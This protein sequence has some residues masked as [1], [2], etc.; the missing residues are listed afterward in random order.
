MKTPIDK[1][2]HELA[3][4]PSVGERTALRMAL[5][6]LRQPVGFGQ[7]LA[8]AL[9]EAVER[10]RFCENCAHITADTYCEYCQDVR[11]DA[12][13]VC[14]VEEVADLLAIER[15]HRYRGVYHVLHGVISPIDG[16]G[17]DDLRIEL[18]LK[19][20]ATGQVREIIL[21]LSPSV[22]GEATS[23]YMTR[24]MRG[25]PVKITK[26]ASGIPV[27]ATIEFIDQNTLSRA[28]EARVEV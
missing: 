24:L 11:R 10:A 3:K 12:S 6:I 26:L 16:V 21:A 7:G 27:G 1:L 25:S 4:L 23:L 17:P 2:V 28:M 22:N 9:R 20:M 19:R 18:L 14:V 8:G 15:T 13:T 5:H